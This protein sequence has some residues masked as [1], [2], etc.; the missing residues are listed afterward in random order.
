M[1]NTG[2]K[3]SYNWEQSHIHP[4]SLFF[5]EI[6]YISQFK[7]FKPASNTFWSVPCKNGKTSISWLNDKRN[8]IYGI[9]ESF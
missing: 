6:P 5:Y 2:D 8:I 4:F 7:V 1:L 9:N 3:T